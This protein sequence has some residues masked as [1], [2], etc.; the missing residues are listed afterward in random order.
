MKVLQISP[1]PKAV[2]GEVFIPGSKSYT[3]RALFL[4]ALS[5]SQSKIINPLIS[6]DTEAMIDCLKLLGAKISQRENILKVYP[7]QKTA[8]YQRVKLNAG[9]SGTTIRFILPLLCILKGTKILTGKAGLNK[10]PIG[11]L[12]SALRRLGAKIKYLKKE[13]FP[14]LQIN[15]SKLNRENILIKGSISSQFISALLMIMPLSNFSLRVLGR[16]ISKP[17]IDMTLDIMKDFGVVIKTENY[18]K[19]SFDENKEYSAPE[20]YVIEGDLSSGAYFL[21]IGALTKSQITLKNINPDSKQADLKF[22]AILKKMGRKIS[23]GKNSITID[24]KG[25]KALKVSMEDCPDQV[26][27]LAVLAAFAKGKTEIS[28]ISTLKIKETDRIFALRCELKKMGIKTAADKN[29][30]IIY[31]GNPKPAF[32]ETYGDHRMAMAFAVAGAKL[33]SMQIADPDVVNKTFPDFWKSLNALGIKTEKAGLK[34]LILIGMRGSGKTTVS[35]IL[36]GKLGKKVIEVD[37]VIAG[38]EN[39]TIRDIIAKYS[40]N[41]FRKKEAQAVSALAKESG[42][43]ISTGGGIITNT[44]NI[45]VL[46]DNGFLILLN[47]SIETLVKR[48]GNNKERPRLTNAKNLKE[49]IAEIM[50]QRQK[51]YKKTADVIIDTDGKNPKQVAEEIIKRLEV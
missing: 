21:A 34:N 25:V 18:K 7:L 40:W 13:G 26:Q 44:K 4:S 29:K 49:E 5:G 19:Y 14:P 28:G 37:E 47:A 41:Y 45:Q 17:Y 30:L 27:T 11:E 1:L 35:K 31:G 39:I 51:L 9:L 46:K 43:I 24:G 20:E 22:T 15:S 3:N 6:D 16:Q 23:Y 10:R 50:K 8:N 12:V 48:Q 42:K 38:K 33:K 36:S 32:I 2:K